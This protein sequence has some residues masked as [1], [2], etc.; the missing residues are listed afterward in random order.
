[1]TKQSVCQE[2]LLSEFAGVAGSSDVIG[3][4]RAQPTT[5]ARDQCW[6]IVYDNDISA[7]D[8]FAK[9]PYPNCS[10][11]FVGTQVCLTGSASLTTASSASPAS[12]SSLN[13]TANYDPYPAG[14]LS[15]DSLK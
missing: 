5:V 2:N 3:S 9:N 6:T 11:I 12:T 8:F 1:M 4:D 14:A 10:S 15:T 7:D 13:K